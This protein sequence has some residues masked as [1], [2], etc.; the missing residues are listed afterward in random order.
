MIYT[1]INKLKFIILLNLISNFGLKMQKEL[2]KNYLIVDEN[3]STITLKATVDGRLSIFPR[4]LIEEYIE[5]HNQGLINHSMKQRIRRD[6]AKEH[7]IWDKYLHG[8][9]SRIT[10][11]VHYLEKQSTDSKPIKINTTKH[12]NHP[13]NLLLYGPPGTGKSYLLNQRSTNHSH[14]RVLFHPDTTR[15]DFIGTYK[16]TMLYDGSSEC[17]FLPPTQEAPGSH[18]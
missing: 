10:A 4:S 7:S 16:P 3:E 2:N 11:L 17:C 14:Y 6:I 5:F 8:Y 13:N 12:F 9:E 18:C 1:I 15:G